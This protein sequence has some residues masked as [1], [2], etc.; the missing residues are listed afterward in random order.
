M[1]RIVNLPLDGGQNCGL[2]IGWGSECWVY[3][4]VRVKILG[5]WAPNG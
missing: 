4:W 3:H 2:T 5:F 1:V